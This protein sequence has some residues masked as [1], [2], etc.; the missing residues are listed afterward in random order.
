M[1]RRSFLA[2]LFAMPSA[3]LLP[4]PQP[5]PGAFANVWRAPAGVYVG[6]RVTTHHDGTGWV[7]VQTRE[8]VRPGDVVVF[9]DDGR[10]ERM[11][12]GIAEAGIQ[13]A[14]FDRT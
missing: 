5:E 8:R 14:Y 12:V 10:A 11:R 13:N 2:S 6:D 3:V 1:K 4:R 9:G 7:L